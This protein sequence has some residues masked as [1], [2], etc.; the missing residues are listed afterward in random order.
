MRESRKQSM[1]ML[2]PLELREPIYQEVLSGSPCKDVKLLS[3]C[4]Q[5]YAEAQHYLF[6]RPQRFGSQFDLYRWLHRVGQKHLHHVATLGMKLYDINPDDCLGKLDYMNLDKR[7]ST[8]PSGMLFF[9]EEVQRLLKAL[10]YLPNV[11]T[12]TIYKQQDPE[13]R[14]CQD[15]Y[16]AFFPLVAHRYPKLRNLTFYVDQLPLTFLSSLKSLQS[17]RFTGYSTSPPAETLKALQMLPQLKEIELFGPP[18]GLKFQQRA[19]YTGVRRGLSFIPEVLEGVRPLKSFTICELRDPFS[20]TTIFFVEGMLLSLRESHSSSLQTLR[21]SLDFVPTKTS[22]RALFCLLSSCTSLRH[23]EIGG[24]GLDADVLDYLPRSLQTLYISITKTLD[25]ESVAGA[26]RAHRLDQPALR[27][28]VLQTDTRG[29]LSERLRAR[30][31]GAVKQLR[32]IG[33]RASR[34]LW[35]PILLDCLTEE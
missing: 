24:P 8:Q 13:T 35:Y 6:K 18:P 11:H 14:S 12:L 30:V 27:E 20:E 22:L 4:R 2:L 16:H 5:I 25:P 9:E 31:D 28:V 26:I 33:Y 19:G 15:L 17:L 23:L 3:V 32:S 7:G 1:L 10:R 21:I 29:G 34:G